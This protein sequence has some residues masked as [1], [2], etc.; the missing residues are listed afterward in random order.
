MVNLRIPVFAG[1]VVSS[2]M[3]S[4]F[5]FWIVFGGLLERRNDVDAQ[6]VTLIE[7]REMLLR[8]L[9][10]LESENTCAS[11]SPSEWGS[12][13][14]LPP[15]FFDVNLDASV[16]WVIA[17]SEH[18][19]S[20]GSGFF[21]SSSEILT[22]Y[23]VVEGAASGAEILIAAHGHGFVLGRVTLF[24]N[25]ELGSDDLAVITISEPVEWAVP[26]VLSDATADMDLRLVEV[27]AAGFPGAVIESYGSV[28]SMITGNV[29]DLPQLVLTSGVISSNSVNEVGTQI[30]S[31]TAQISQGNSGG[32]LVNRCGVVVGVNTFIHSD[33]G[34][35]RSFS[36]GSETLRS[37]LSIGS[38][39][40]SVT[41]QE[42]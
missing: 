15:E 17:N 26:L 24:G 20:S 7:Q 1:L 16:V 36:I 40:Y 39:S 8:E 33:S 2:V 10:E 25:S 27:V 4:L 14:L 12:P 23:H 34:G 38:V 9:E 37:F 41:E 30:I 18:G 3:A 22:N 29:L 32:A 31:H 6:F 5:L 11:V 21:I 42:C 35:V 28:D 19:V 13:D